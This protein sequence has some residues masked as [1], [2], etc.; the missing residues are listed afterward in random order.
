MLEGLIDYFKKLSKIDE[1]QI[2][3]DVLQ[4]AT[5]QAQ[6][7][8]LNQH[9]LYDEGIQ[10]DGTETGQYAIKTIQY[11][12][13][14]GDSRGVPGNTSHITGNDT[15]QTYDSMRVQNMPDRFEIV[16]DDRNHFFDREP[17]GLGLTNES[18]DEIVPEIKDGIIEKIQEAI[19]RKKN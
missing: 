5:L 7:I 8:D 11:K 10:A 2:L 17:D 12:Q 4:D 6:I 1:N 19:A 16:A 3:H 18:I 9:Q 14:Y 15:G 13:A